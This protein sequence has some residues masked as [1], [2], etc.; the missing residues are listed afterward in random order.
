MRITKHPSRKTKISDKQAE[1]FTLAAS[2][3]E[4]EEEGRFVPNTDSVPPCPALL[5]RIDRAA[6]KR[7]LNRSSW[8]RYAA[9]KDLESPELKMPGRFQNV[10]AR[11]EDLS[12]L[13]P[14]EVNVHRCGTRVRFLLHAREASSGNFGA[15]M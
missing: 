11:T 10:H 9:T 12:A 5:A 8:I 4:T 3:N 15:I 6:K 7:G 13:E 2:A 14:A 1:K